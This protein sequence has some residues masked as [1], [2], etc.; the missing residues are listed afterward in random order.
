M[1]VYYAA[2]KG[3]KRYVSF[4]RENFDIGCSSIINGVKV[5]LTPLCAM[6]SIKA[7]SIMNEKSI[8]VYEIK[9]DDVIYSE[10][11]DSYIHIGTEK[12]RYLYSIGA[13][14]ICNIL[15]SQSHII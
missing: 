6:E 4:I 3:N 14:S 13:S 12:P 15:R 10:K 1:G 9:S 8:S 11:I 2:L 7:D 5:Y